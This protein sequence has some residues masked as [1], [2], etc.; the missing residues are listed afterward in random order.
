[1]GVKLDKIFDSFTNNSIFNNKLKQN[2]YYRY[3]KKLE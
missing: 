2:V 3:L 1:M